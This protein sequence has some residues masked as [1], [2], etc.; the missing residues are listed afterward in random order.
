[1]EEQGFVRHSD[2]LAQEQV[3]RSEQV[4]GYQV[5]TSHPLAS[6]GRSLPP[7]VGRAVVH[8]RA[9]GNTTILTS[10]CR[11]HSV[12]SARA[13]RLPG[14]CTALDGRSDAAPMLSRPA[15]SRA[16]T[17]P[18]GRRRQ[19]RRARP[20]SGDGPCSP[21]VE[22]GASLPCLATDP[23]PFRIRALGVGGPGGSGDSRRGQVLPTMGALVEAAGSLQSN[24]RS[25]VSSGG[26]ASSSFRGPRY[27]DR[28]Q[29]GDQQDGGDQERE[30]GECGHGNP[31]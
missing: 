11:D 7:G 14:P 25:Q 17:A 2:T 1:M 22:R 27:D 16:S 4:E 24:H 21:N 29:H 6:L 23:M 31:R 30:D 13:P 3:D 9:A 8:D 19:R 28:D 12:T 15:R 20:Q 10:S 26:P 5:L 18:R